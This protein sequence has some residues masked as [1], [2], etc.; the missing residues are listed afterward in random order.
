MR[1]RGF[2]SD[3]LRDLY[4][5]AIRQK[6]RAEYGKRGSGHAYVY[7]PQEGCYFREAFS[8]SGRGWPHEIASKVGNMR[9]HGLM[10]KGR[11][12]KHTAALLTGKETED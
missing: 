6:W 8:L 7:C 9:K 11:G 10:W 3:V 5:A 4:R 1:K 12:G 2:T